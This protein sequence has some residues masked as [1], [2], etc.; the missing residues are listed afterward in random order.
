MKKPDTNSKLHIHALVTVIIMI[1]IFVQSA[2]PSD[3][4]QQESGVI[5]SFLSNFL[6]TDSELLSFVVRKCA[7]FAEYTLLGWSLAL[8][9]ADYLERLRETRRDVPSGGQPGG[10]NRAKPGDLRGAQIIAPWLIGTA[11]AVTDEIHQYF[12]PGRSCEV[13]DVV[14]D[15]CGVLVGALI[16][17]KLARRAPKGSCGPESE[18]EIQ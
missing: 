11:Y 8:T 17:A 5:V 4:S 18:Q 9:V 15:S 6:W 3:L 2:L 10:S 14:I 13:R 16:V 1:F 7:H 12:V